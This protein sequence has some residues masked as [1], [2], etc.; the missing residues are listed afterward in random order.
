MTSVW[1]DPVGLPIGESGA[2]VTVGTFDGVHRG[3]HDVL[4]RLVALAT[5]TKRPSVVVTFEPHPLEVVRPADAPPLLTLH[6]EK[7]E[8]FAQCGVSYVAVLPFTPILASYEAEQ[9]VDAVLIERF[10]VVEL[11][12][13]HDHGFGR[14][15][16]GDI[17]V[18]QALGASRGF[19][20]TV[21]PPVHAADG[22]AISSTAIRSAILKG[23]LP[24]A[25]AGLGR[26]YSLAG[27]VIR[28]DQRGR[29]IGYP[30]LNLLP[31]PLRKLLPPDGVYAVRVQ[32]PQGPFGGMLNLGPRPTFGDASRRIETH[33]FDATHDWYGAPIR[34]D[35]IARIRD[36]QAY[37]GIEALR[38]Q[39]ALDEA[40]ARQTLQGLATATSA[41]PL[42]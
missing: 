35:L 15:R 1:S 31:P 25:A 42:S 10:R 29:L 39:L 3:H 17:D 4:A 6:D 2:V 36:T 22:Q 28:G 13:G 26:P 21:L 7:L 37:S 5:A 24:T 11:L 23:D 12:V 30:T 8:M 9:F 18:L 40:A 16:L 41:E 27:T 34:L 33:V 14:G 32:T 38:A 20:V 19:G